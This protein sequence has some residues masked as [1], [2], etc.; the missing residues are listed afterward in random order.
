MSCFLAIC[1]FFQ[2]HYI[3]WV[4]VKKNKKKKQLKDILHVCI[5]YITSYAPDHYK[6]VIIN[7]NI[8]IKKCFYSLV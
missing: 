4:Y 2:H 5:K 6:V 3:H 8:E 7:T 1:A